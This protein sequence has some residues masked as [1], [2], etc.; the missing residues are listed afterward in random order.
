MLNDII[1]K[2]PKINT[3]SKTYNVIKDVTGVL[4]G[5][6]TA[7]GVE[8]LFALG[9][10]VCFPKSRLGR[11]LCT[12]ALIPICVGGMIIGTAATRAS[13]NIM[14][15]CWNGEFPVPND[16]NE[17][18]P[19][20]NN[21][22][23]DSKPVTKVRHKIQVIQDVMRHRF[24]FNKNEDAVNFVDSCANIYQSNKELL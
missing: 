1:S 14:A 7:I 24:K 5:F 3:N 21:E 8:G 2:L 12:P 17:E 19:I 23:P 22:D 9:V 18:A 20:P 10:H 4:G 16:E 13:I 15:K 6:G 11:I